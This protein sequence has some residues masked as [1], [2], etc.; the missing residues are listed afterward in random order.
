MVTEAMI[1]KHFADRVISEG[2]KKIYATQQNIV[3]KYRLERTGL[4]KQML[5]RRPFQPMGDRVYYMSTLTYLRFL[6]MGKR[7]YMD[8]QR[9]ELSIYNRVVWGVLYGETMSQLRYGYTAEI[10]EY[11]RRALED[12]ERE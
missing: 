12:A 3:A 10:K 7:K 1:Q 4:L 11:I 5:G 6:D 2:V 8:N 9:R